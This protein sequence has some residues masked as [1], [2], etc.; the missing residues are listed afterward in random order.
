LNNPT[1]AN[2]IASP[3]E[4]TVYTVEVSDGYTTVTQD[5][6][7]T[8][9]DVPATPFI[10]LDGETLHSDAATGNQWY[11][12][13]GPIAGATGQSYTCTYED[14]YHVRVSNA[15]GCESDPS[16]SIHVVVSGIDELSGLNNLSVFPNPFTNKVNIEFKL[17]QG[18]N[19]TLAVFNA[20]GQEVSVISD[21]QSATGQ[22][23]TFEVSA[24][25][26]E[27]GIY[28]CKLITGEQVLIQK[29]V[30]TK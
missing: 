18:T 5:A 8:V 23:Q 22:I 28:F 10:E 9:H 16:N 30:H 13:Q 6:T 14:V 11:D 4:T 17:E 19:F 27:K 29:M 26:M 12:S 7:I 25:G 3:T 20:L 1:I 24:A 21:N 15:F 2:P